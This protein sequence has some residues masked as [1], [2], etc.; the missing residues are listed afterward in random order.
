VKSGAKLRA[1]QR[2]TPEPNDAVDAVDIA[3]VT[4]VVERD[5]HRMFLLK[6]VASW[7]SIAK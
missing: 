4:Q 3:D 5:L 7:M 1:R 6:S 2:L